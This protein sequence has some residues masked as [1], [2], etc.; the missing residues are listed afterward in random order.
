MR[1]VVFRARNNQKNPYASCQNQKTM[2]R[3]PRRDVTDALALAISHMNA[4]KHNR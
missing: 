4:L 3:L 1:F 2:Y